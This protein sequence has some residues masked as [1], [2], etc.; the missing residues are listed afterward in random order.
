MA[1]RSPLRAGSFS[2]DGGLDDDEDDACGLREGWHHSR[3]Q[4]YLKVLAKDLAPEAVR[5]GTASPRCC[6]E[7]NVGHLL[8]NARACAAEAEKGGCRCMAVVK[9]DAYGHG[10]AVVARSLHTHCGIDFFAVAT[11]P[12]ALELRAAGL[13]EP[14][15]VL[16]LGAS[17]PSE[18]PVYA[19]FGLE[20]V[21]ESSRTAMRLGCLPESAGPLRVHVM[22]NTGMN[23]IGLQTF[24]STTETHGRKAES[25]RRATLRLDDVF[26]HLGPVPEDGADYPPPPPVMTRSDSLGSLGSAG[27]QQEYHGV[28]IDGAVEVIAALAAAP[29]VTLAGLCTHMADATANIHRY[30]QRQFGR[31]RDVV[32]ALSKRGVDVPCVHVENSQTLLDAHVGPERMRQLLDA[33]GGAATGYCRVGGALYGQRHHACLKPVLSL[34]A[35]VR[36]VARLEKGMTV[37]YDRSWIAQRDCIIATLSLGFADGFPRSLS[38]QGTVCIRGHQFR[39]A[40]KV[41]MDMLMVDLGELGTRG[42]GDVRVGDYAVLWGEGGAS[43]S[44]TADQLGTAQSDLTCDLSRRVARRYVNLPSDWVT[45]PDLTY[46]C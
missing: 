3:F 13:V 6:A 46:A 23:R 42:A 45:P 29:A 1:R 19:R 16:V 2:T 8:S 27:R 37:G 35:Q 36:H 7:I 31:F 28:Q 24:D 18:W 34:R 12:E 38:N 44:D 4:P 21:V 15:R 9:A 20:L 22:L 32:V 40:G 43:L 11:L 10:A 5:L 39:V 33:T 30:T 25:P 41:C 14:V 26:K 17:V